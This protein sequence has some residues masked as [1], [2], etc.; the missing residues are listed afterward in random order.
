MEV[1]ERV[2]VR[3]DIAGDIAGQ[4]QLTVADRGAGC[5]VWLVSELSARRGALKLVSALVPPIAR[6]GHDWVLDSGAE[7][8][9]KSAL[10]G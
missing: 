6:R 3:A 2:L 8:F 9:R 7:Q 4:A 5:E 10:A 1:V